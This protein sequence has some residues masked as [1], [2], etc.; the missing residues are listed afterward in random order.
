MNFIT[1][2]QLLRHDKVL[3]LEPVITI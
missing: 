2:K 1:N 3:L